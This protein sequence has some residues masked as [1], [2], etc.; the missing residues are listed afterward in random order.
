MTYQTTHTSKKAKN[1]SIE[2]KPFMSMTKEAAQGPD[3]Q[4][5]LRQT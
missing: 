1:H 4:K 5:I 2:C 3:V